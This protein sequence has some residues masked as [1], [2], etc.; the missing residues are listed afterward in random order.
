VKILVL[1]SRFP[2][3][4]EKGD[5]LRAYHQ[6]RE[7]SKQHDIVLCTLT[8]G[9]VKDDD[10]QAVKQYCSAIYVFPLSFFT[11]FKNIIRGLLRGLPVSV[12]Y[13]FNDKI[14]SKILNISKKEKPDH[15][16]CQLIR[17]SEYVKNVPITKTLDY[18]DAFSS[19][20]KRRAESSLFLWRPI[21]KLE[22]LFLKKYEKNIRQYFNSATIISTQDRDAIFTEGGDIDVIPNG[23]DRD[24]F[25]KDWSE[26][27]QPSQHD[28]V[29]V[30]NMGY[31]PNVIA[32]VFLIKKILPILKKDMPNIKA[33]IAGTRPTREVLSLASDNVM[34]SGW[35]PDIRSAYSSAKIFVAP[36]FHGSGQQN[37][38]LEAMAMEMPCV[39]TTLVN[40][41]ILANPGTA[42]L[43]ADTEGVFAEKILQLMQDIH[44]QRF[45]GH[46]ARHFVENRYDWAYTTA[47]LNELIDN[48]K[49]SIFD[50]DKKK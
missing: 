37:K 36:I 24:F 17:M 6:I 15:I 29:F 35:L 5:K 32:A 46:N 40:N 41:A 42:I 30:G 9:V 28:I 13:F 20:M 25:K 34:I 19:G 18:M 7:L 14:R 44:Y 26:K 43:V 21:L 47:C 45:I 48:S 31:Y 16:Y 2:Y 10:F 4:I 33:L 12:G 27:I 49:V 38:I 23:V 22:S 3:P 39:T 11:I 1:T 8:E 50:I